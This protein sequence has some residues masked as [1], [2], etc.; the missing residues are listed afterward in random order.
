[1]EHLLEQF[2]QHQYYVA[3]EMKND[4][5]GQ[6]WFKTPENVYSIIMGDQFNYHE[7]TD[8]LNKYTSRR[9]AIANILYLQRQNVVLPFHE[10]EG[11][12][13][14]NVNHNGVV[15]S[16]ITGYETMMPVS[17]DIL[18]NRN[19]HNEMVKEFYK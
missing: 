16:V 12:I 3:Q 13:I 2:I 8:L 6:L 7:L 5:I 1:M 17:L 4:Q 15:H 10:F 9:D 11:S 18:L 14:H 19:R